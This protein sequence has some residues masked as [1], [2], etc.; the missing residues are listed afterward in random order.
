MR[1]RLWIKIPSTWKLSTPCRLCAL[2][3][4]IM[5]PVARN[6]KIIWSV[7]LFLP[8]SRIP[9]IARLSM[10]DNVH[11]TSNRIV[12]YLRH[13]FREFWTSDV[14]PATF[15]TKFARAKRS[16]RTRRDRRYIFACCT[17]YLHIATER[18]RNVILSRKVTHYICINYIIE[19][20]LLIAFYFIDNMI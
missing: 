4:A 13:L 15:A 16:P 7:L 19:D 17:I 2:K 3:N 11:G 6:L 9:L 1:I 18:I 12:L 10:R 8:R 20:L 5:Y 14:A